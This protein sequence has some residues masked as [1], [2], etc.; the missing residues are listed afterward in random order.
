MV[1]EEAEAIEIVTSKVQ[2]H[3]TDF[4][5]LG[6][7]FQGSS[8]VLSEVVNPSHCYVF[9]H[10]LSLYE[11]KLFFSAARTRKEILF[12]SHISSLDQKKHMV[13]KDYFRVHGLEEQEKL[14][15][16]PYDTEDF[17]ARVDGFLASQENLFSGELKPF[18]EGRK[19][20]DIPFDWGP[21]K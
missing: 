2:E 7:I 15:Q 3:L 20:E 12:S 10:M 18:I 4:Q 9:Q 16:F 1:L 5:E 11:I 6:L 13:V 14:F 8:I 19:W 21:Y 17:S